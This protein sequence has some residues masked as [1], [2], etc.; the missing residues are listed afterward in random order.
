MNFAHGAD[1]AKF[2][3][4]SA[5]DPRFDVRNSAVGRTT[6]SRQLID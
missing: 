6:E 2:D 4:H 3:C 5:A 1:L